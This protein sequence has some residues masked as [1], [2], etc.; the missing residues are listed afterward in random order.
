MSKNI[1]A[2]AGVPTLPQATELYSWCIYRLPEECRPCVLVSNVMASIREERIGSKKSASGCLFDK[3]GEGGG[4][5]LFGRCPYGG[6]TF[7]KEASQW[8]SWYCEPAECWQ[9]E[10]SKISPPAYW[11]NILLSKRS[12]QIQKEN[13]WALG[14]NSV[15]QRPSFESVVTWVKHWKL[16][17]RKYVD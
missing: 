10:R 13:V 2:E 6:N 9:Q 3:G 8:R 1:T 5:K 17:I 16:C 14:Y 11:T 7:Q 12:H 15:A 4:Q